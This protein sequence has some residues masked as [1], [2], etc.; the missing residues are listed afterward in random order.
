MRLQHCI[1]SGG[2]HTLSS[3]QGA[4]TKRISSSVSIISS[5]WIGRI[6]HFILG[7]ERRPVRCGSR[8]SFF[9]ILSTPGYSP[10]YSRSLIFRKSPTSTKSGAICSFKLTL[11]LECFFTKIS[12]VFSASLNSIGKCACANGE[13]TLN[14]SAPQI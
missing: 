12:G 1:S 4:W 9:P 10:L 6:S 11:P 3:L 14:H 8:K 13:M 2:N 7:F 5:S